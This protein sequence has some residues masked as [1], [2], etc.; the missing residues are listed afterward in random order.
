[1]YLA[2]IKVLLDVSLKSSHIHL[3][4]KQRTV[5][6]FQN[7]VAALKEIPIRILFI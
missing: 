7:L 6:F 1:M 5:L 2:Y 3:S 4:R